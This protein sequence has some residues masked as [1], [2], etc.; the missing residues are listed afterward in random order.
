MQNLLRLIRL[1]VGWVETLPRTKYVRLKTYH[2]RRA[3]LLFC[4][5]EI[6]AMKSVL[7]QARVHVI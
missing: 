3:E 7:R 1:R 5:S 4:P 6:P 2:A